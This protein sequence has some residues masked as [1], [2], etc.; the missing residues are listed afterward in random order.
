[1]FTIKS[2]N[3]V[4]HVHVHK[5]IEYLQYPGTARTF[6]KCL[7]VNKC[8]SDASYFLNMYSRVHD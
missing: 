5:V 6:T 2:D 3:A 8:A 7:Y 4:I 1:M